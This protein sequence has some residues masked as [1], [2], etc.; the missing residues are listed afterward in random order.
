MWVANTTRFYYLVPGLTFYCNI[1]SVAMLLA[2][3]SQSFMNA[4]K[5]KLLYTSSKNLFKLSISN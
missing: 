4:N 5:I 1:I 3:I 2:F